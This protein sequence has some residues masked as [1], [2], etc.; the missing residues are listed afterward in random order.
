MT[1]EDRNS[2]STEN[3]F[4]TRK[5]Q[6]R[7]TQFRLISLSAIRHAE[8]IIKNTPRT[9]QTA[10]NK[11]LEA[12][13]NG[14]DVSSVAFHQQNLRK[15]GYSLDFIS[16]LTRAERLKHVFKSLS[17]AIKPS[18]TSEKY[19]S[20]NP[21][22]IRPLEDIPPRGLKDLFTFMDEDRWKAQVRGTIMGNVDAIN[23]LQLDSLPLLSHTREM[24]VNRATKVEIQP[25]GTAFYQFPTR[26]QGISLKYLYPQGKS[27]LSLFFVINPL[28]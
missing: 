11:L 4:L 17:L 18:N 7:E 20:L 22:R 10:F 12:W 19:I 5:Y 13:D 2:N 1:I 8:D 16:E 26:V 28:K 3:D 14:R 21:G 25:D 27:A 6:Y 24:I 15:L 23:L 9:Q